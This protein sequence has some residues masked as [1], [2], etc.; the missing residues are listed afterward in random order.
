MEGGFLCFKVICWNSLG[1]NEQKN[2]KIMKKHG[3]I[4]GN[5][6]LFYFTTLSVS[7]IIVACIVVAMQRPRD[8]ANKQ[9]LFLGNGSVNTFQRQRIWTQKEKNGVSMWSL[10]RSI[11]QVS[12]TSE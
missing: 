1:G 3:F 5:Y 11:N 4:P 6:L 7:Q 12:W 2:R 9:R 8:K 10:P